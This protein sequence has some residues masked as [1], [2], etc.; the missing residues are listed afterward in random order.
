MA[1]SAHATVA[2]LC[3]TENDVGFLQAGWKAIMRDKT[4]PTASFEA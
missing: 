4:M 3:S 1:T 2:S